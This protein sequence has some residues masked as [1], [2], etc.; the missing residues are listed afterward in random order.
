M[1]EEYNY[2]VYDE[3]FNLVYTFKSYSRSE[4]DDIAPDHKDYI[5]ALQK[6]QR[7]RDEWW[8]KRDSRF[9]AKKGTTR[10]HG[11]LIRNGILYRNFRDEDEVCI[12]PPTVKI[13][14]TA[15][16]FNM[17]QLKSVV[18]PS[19]VTHIYPNAFCKCQ[20]LESAQ[21]PERAELGEAAFAW[22][23]KL[24]QVELPIKYRSMNRDELE[25]Y[26]RNSGIL[27]RSGK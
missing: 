15:A 17:K 24:T 4:F 16:F 11:L 3:F 5:A 8:A 6:I 22:C 20:N 12:V 25:K 21:L 18:I 23:P 13:I 26:F 14:Y 10:Q 2:Y 19:S 27:E 9:R 1:T 7:Q